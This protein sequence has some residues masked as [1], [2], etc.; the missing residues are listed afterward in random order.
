[1]P[2]FKLIKQLEKNLKLVEEETPTNFITKWFKKFRMKE[3]SKRI[4]VLRNSIKKK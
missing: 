2:K 1:M 4:C 3:I